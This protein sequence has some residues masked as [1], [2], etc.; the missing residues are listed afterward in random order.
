M[1]DNGFSGDTI[2]KTIP[3]PC[4]AP[5]PTSLPSLSTIAKVIEE[6]LKWTLKL[7]VSSYKIQREYAVKVFIKNNFSDTF[8]LKVIKSLQS[9]M[10]SLCSKPVLFLRYEEG[11]VLELNSCKY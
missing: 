11:K 5:P 4:P 8:L 6:N 3:Q 10:I 7:I 2:T 9:N 1:T